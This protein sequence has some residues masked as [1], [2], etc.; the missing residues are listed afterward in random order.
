[1]QLLSFQQVKLMTLKERIIRHKDGAIIFSDFFG[2]FGV[3][4]VRNTLS[5][6]TNEGILVRLSKGVYYK[7][8]RTRLGILYPQVD[9]VIK[10]IAK[11]DHAKILPTGNTAM[12]QL[13]LTTQ[14]PMNY[15][16]LTNGAARKLQIGNHT[17][18][19]KHGVATNFAF[20]G[21]F[22]PVLHQALRAIGQTNLT[23]EHIAQISKLVRDNFEPNTMRYDIK[24]LP[25]WERKIVQPIIE[26]C[27]EQMD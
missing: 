12:Y 25:A 23:A 7:P 2:N 18:T 5:K 20:R 4:T 17:I 3:G 9:E 21:K 16:Y 6:L 22:M 27:Y 19:L 8:V 26:N 11:R 10:A 15:E 1:M 14:V 13:G 24:L